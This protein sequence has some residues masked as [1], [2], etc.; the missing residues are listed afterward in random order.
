MLRS[1]QMLCKIVTTVSEILSLFN[2]VSLCVLTLQR[3]GF[4]RKV[5]PAVSVERVAVQQCNFGG[6]CALWVGQEQVLF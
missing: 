1:L 4:V 2:Y 3:K 6:M 5:S